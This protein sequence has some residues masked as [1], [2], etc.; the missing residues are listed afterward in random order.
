[1]T[2]GGRLSE[3][4]PKFTPPAIPIILTSKD[5]DKRKGALAKVAGKTG[6][7]DQCDKV[8]AA[9]K[10]VDWT[11][12][13]IYDRINDAMTLTFRNDQFTKAN[14]DKVMN[15][16]KA[17]VLG[18]IA[19]LSAE[20]EKLHALCDKTAKKFATNKAIPKASLEHVKKMAAEADKLRGRLSQQALS[21]YL[22]SAHGGFSGWFEDVIINQMRTDSQGVPRKPDIV[23]LMDKLKNDPTPANVNAAH[24]T[25]RHVTQPL[26]NIAKIGER[27]FGPKNP[28]ARAAFE[29]LTPYANGN[30]VPDSMHPA[31]VLE[32]VHKLE[33]IWQNAVQTLAGVQL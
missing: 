17:E 32:V 18:P 28:K 29:E 6:I 33:P 25:I 9:S 14:Y 30:F 1:M 4:I 24:S 20:A 2:A 21:R 5:W 19:K 26:G 8:V 23:G 16:A 27:G 12:L 22:E 10:P 11:R 3:R 13:D 31:E 7:G 15:A